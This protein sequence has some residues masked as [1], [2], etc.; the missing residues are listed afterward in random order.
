[1]TT[2]TLKRAL[3]TA[4][5]TPALLLAFAPAQAAAPVA[6]KPKPPVL[7]CTT[8]T[9]EGLSYT[10]IKPGKGE[11]PNADSKVTVNYKGML[12]A[13]G[14]EFDSGQGAQFPVGGVIPGF[15]QGLQLMQAGGSYRLCIPA[16]LGYGAAGTGPIPANADLVFEVDLLSFTN[17]PR[18]PI[19]PAAERACSQS[20]ATG[21]GF[22]VVKST[23]GKKPIDGDIALVDFTIFDAASGVVQQKSEW[24][25]IPLSQASPIFSESL[26][27]M[28]TGSAYRFCMPK[29]DDGAAESNIIVTLIDL[30]PAPSGDK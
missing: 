30:R 16:A 7:S 8:T 11:Q 9:A 26:K 24:E 18:K 4:A 23:A 28:Q 14:T 6:V 1:M 19:I 5:L 12:T 21:L 17:P 3:I 27:M 15:A 10:V 20:T 25:K 22:E 2:P 29:T 13:D